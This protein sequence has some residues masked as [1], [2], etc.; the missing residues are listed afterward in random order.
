MHKL[1]ACQGVLCALKKIEKTHKDGRGYKTIGEDGG[2][3][4]PLDRE[5][6]L[7]RQEGRGEAEERGEEGKGRKRRG[8]KGKGQVPNNLIGPLPNLKDFSQKG[9]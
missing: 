4:A 8:T 7:R 3:I 5:V 2:K 6:A 1:K 9:H